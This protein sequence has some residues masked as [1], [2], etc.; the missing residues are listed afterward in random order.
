MD[1]T[2][3]LGDPL[4][5]NPTLRNVAPR[6]GFAYSPSRKDGWL[7]KLTGG[8]N[9]M[10]IRGGAG[11]YYDPLLYSTY[12]NMTFKHEPFFKQVRITNAPFPNVYPLLAG[13]QGLIDTF[14]IQYDPESTYVEQYNVN[15]QRAFSSRAVATIGYVGSHGVHLWREADVNTAYPLTPDGTRFAPV[16]N[17]QRRNPNFANIRMKMADGESFYNAAVFGLQSRVGAGFRAQLSYTYGKSTDDQSS[18]L[19]RNEFANGQAR[20]VDPYNRL[21]NRGRSDFDIRHN[22]S[23][24]FTYDVPFGTGRDHGAGAPAVLRALL[25][26]WQMSGIL[27]AQSGIPVS[28]IFTFDQDRDATT[29]NEQRPDWAPGV[30]STSRVSDTQLFDPLAFVLPAVGSRG[31]VGRNV[32][33]GPGLITFDPAFV[34]SFHVDRAGKRSA[35]LRVEVFNAFNR[36]NFAIPPIA[37]LTVF[38]SP[39]ERNSTAGQI[40]S[41][42]TPARQVQLSLRMLF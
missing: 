21:L 15:V 28:P 36:V 35:Q 20:S 34:K 17:P 38:N 23:I 12:G 8:E 13:G 33:D 5:L 14:A 1:P 42:S 24:N 41:T 19:G 9:A 7:A 2:S 31:N 11:L 40:T 4:F 6:A 27:T 29:D 32:I 10:A 26:G 3:T 37:N 16:A 25:G 30:S 22:L 39:T 18:S